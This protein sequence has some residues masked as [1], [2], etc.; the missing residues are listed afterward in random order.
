MQRRDFLRD[1]GLGAV[2]ILTAPLGLSAGR[3][4]QPNVII[5]YTDDQ[6]FQQ[7]GSYGGPVLTPYMDRLAAGGVRFNE[8]HV[9]SPVCSPSRYSLLTGRYAGR[10]EYLNTLY[11]NHQQALI[12]WNTY[13]NGK[14][15]TL[16]HILSAH[17]YRTGMVGKWHLGQPEL[18]PVPAE[19]DPRE[20]EIARIVR[21]NYEIQR[22][23]V[24]RTSGFQSVECLYG[25]NYNRIG[26]P[27]ALQHHN[28]EWLTQG[29][30]NFIDV[31]PERPFFLYIAHTVPH[32]PTA[33]DSLYADPRMT[34]SGILAKPPVVQPSREDVLERC[35]RNSIL[36]HKAPF[37]WVDDSV[38]AVMKRLDS[39]GI[40][41]DT[42]IVL[43]SDH[44]P[45]SGKMTPY[46]AGAR[47]PA[48]FYWPRRIE[49]RQENN[50]LVSNIDV[51]P[52]ILDLCDVT[53]PKGLD[54]DGRSLAPILLQEEKL[55]SDALYLEIVFTRG[56]RTPR[57][58]YIAVRYPPEIQDRITSETRDQFNFSGEMAQD[59]YRGDE[60][61][62]GYHDA[63]QLYDLENDPEEQVNLFNDP[64][65]AEIVREMR[66][67]LTGYSRRIP[68]RFAEFS[69]KEFE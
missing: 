5:I 54:P 40:L 63:D 49:P 29:A 7:L 43:A 65:Y 55:H 41:K 12:Q 30:L 31:E 34:P 18:T 32:G 20:P 62:P 9:S 6:G 16:A 26:V 37:T 57:W 44:G 14:E 51:A 10:C 1:F 17:G 25:A 3:K 28:V 11:P 66:A 2:S 35:K 47:S 42:M 52:T 24:L 67:Y 39:Y 27:L 46:E 45:N 23:E 58:K 64:T 48:L 60:K 68:H 8:Y 13:L 50:D 59:R 56:V 53:I 61:F 21:H 36:D 15:L 69:P 22:E 4:R 38:G 19:A 33:L